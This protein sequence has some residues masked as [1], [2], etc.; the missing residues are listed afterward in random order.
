MFKID[1]PTAIGG[2]V[3]G[4]LAKGKVEQ[5]KQ[6]FKSIYASALE[7]YKESFEDSQ[8]TNNGGHNGN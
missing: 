6:K 8:T 5:T 1:W 2:V 4:Y 3:V 7:N